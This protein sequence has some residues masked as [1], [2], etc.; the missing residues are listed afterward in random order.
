MKPETL[1]SDT[2]GGCHFFAVTSQASARVFLGGVAALRRST[3]AR[4]GR[5]AEGG[6]LGRSWRQKSDG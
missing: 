2:Y 1:M 3:Q 6:E 4:A 5:T